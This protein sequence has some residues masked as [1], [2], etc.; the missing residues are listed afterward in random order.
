MANTNSLTNE[1]LQALVTA[2]DD[3]KAAALR[4]LRGEHVSTPPSAPEPLLTLAALG[5][6]LNL[7]P[8]TI[9]RWKVPAH[10]FGSR[11]RYRLSEVQTY[12]D[13]PDLQ[14]RIEECRAARRKRSRPSPAE[15]TR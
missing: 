5:R 2:D 13:S 12:L 10:R 11:P 7:H 9:W 3:R 4:I 1:I 14:R 6:I 15:V 8:A